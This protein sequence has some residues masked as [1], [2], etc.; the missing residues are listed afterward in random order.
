MPTIL[1]VE[2][3]P[4]MLRLLE[5]NL[6]EEGYRSET[7]PDAEAGLKLLRQEKV[8]LVLTDLKLPLA[9]RRDVLCVSDRAGIVVCLPVRP[10]ERVKVTDAT[11]NVLRIGVL[12]GLAG[13]E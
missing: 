11:R 13:G 7:A 8:D 3:E 5:L 2:D 1:I 6:S 9:A 10:D 12:D 4:R